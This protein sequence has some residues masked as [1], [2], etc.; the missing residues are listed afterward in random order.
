MEHGD[1]IIEE[2]VGQRSFDPKELAEA[3]M[4]N[5][6]ITVMSWGAN[7]WT[8]NGEQWL[9][10]KVQ[11]FFHKGLVYIALGW[12]DTFTIYY[13]TP[14]GTIVD[15][16]RE[17]YVDELIQILDKRIEYIDDYKR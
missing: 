17:V 8:V 4:K 2:K 13:T 3:L 9:R 7:S 14:T 5:A 6:P 16:K 1:K 10:F 15:I 11:G 12:N